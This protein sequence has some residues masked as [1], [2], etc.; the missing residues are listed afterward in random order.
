MPFYFQA[1]QGISAITSSI[2]VTRLSIVVSDAIV[3][4]MAT[5]R[6]RYPPLTE[7]WSREDDVPIGN[8]ACITKLK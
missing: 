4:K 5:K 7:K 3:P 6:A 8:G 1:V 2:R